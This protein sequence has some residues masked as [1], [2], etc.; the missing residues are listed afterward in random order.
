MEQLTVT[1][2]L[3]EIKTIKARIDKKRENV[4]R[5]FARY[6]RERDPLER[7]GGCVEFVRKERQGIGDLEQRIITIRAA[8]Q[9]AN[10]TTRLTIRGTER[11]VMDWLSWRR[12]IA[13]DANQFVNELAQ[14]SNNLRQQARTQGRKV[15]EKDPGEAVEEIVV[16]YSEVE[17]ARE[18]EDM[19][20]LLGELDGKLSL[21]NATTTIVLQ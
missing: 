12:E 20:A 14:R 11:T 19:T 17:L 21:V 2:A 13:N 7:E 6:A 5:Y 18:V 16:A 10:M 9:Q 1:E 3:A 4:R 15:V 8:I